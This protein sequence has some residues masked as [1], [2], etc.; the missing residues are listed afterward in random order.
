MQLAGKKVVFTGTLVSM[1]RSEAEKLV[2]EQ[3]GSAQ[4]SVSSA[5]N[6]VVYGDGAGSKLE[7]AKKLGLETMTEEEF[8]KKINQ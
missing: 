7:K 4:S 2:E 6:I 3:G 1:K 8:L 5:T